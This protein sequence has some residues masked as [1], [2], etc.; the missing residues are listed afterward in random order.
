MNLLHDKLSEMQEIDELEYI[1]LLKFTDTLI[2]FLAIEAKCKKLINSKKLSL[3]FAKNVT[4]FYVNQ[5][6]VHVV[7]ELDHPLKCTEND[8]VS[9]QSKRN[10][11]N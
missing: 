2:C 1:S 7:D 8:F 5:S 10:A 3:K 9:W 4:L 11:R 6:E